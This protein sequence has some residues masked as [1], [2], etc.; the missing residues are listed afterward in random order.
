MT[1]V[2][3]TCTPH[4]KGLAIIGEPLN[5]KGCL[6]D[7]KMKKNHRYIRGSKKEGGV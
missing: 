2:G 1:N 4:P 5:G 7:K 6:S 3:E